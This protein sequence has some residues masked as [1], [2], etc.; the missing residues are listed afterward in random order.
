MHTLCN[1]FEP[2]GRTL[3][4]L[5]FGVLFAKALNIIQQK[6]IRMIVMMMMMNI[7]VL[8]GDNNCDDDVK[9]KP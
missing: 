1:L 9:K 5:K 2:T 6:Y 4:Q 8:V 3:H 7:V